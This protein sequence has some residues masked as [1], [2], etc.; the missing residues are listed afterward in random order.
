MKI[1][2]SI[3]VVLPALLIACH[4]KAKEV[5]ADQKASVLNFV[6]AFRND[7]AIHEVN[8]VRVDAMGVLYVDYYVYTA[9]QK[10]VLAGVEAIESDTTASY[11][12]AGDAHVKEYRNV[13]H[14]DSLRFAP[15]EKNEQNGFFWRH[16]KLKKRKVYECIKAPFH[17]ILIFDMK[18]DTVYHWISEIRD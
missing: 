17:H 12:N 3:L 10:K 5:Q 11:Y 8:G 1:V 2:K 7:P 18:S 9:P 13:L 14:H 6:H 16:E 4:R 15:E